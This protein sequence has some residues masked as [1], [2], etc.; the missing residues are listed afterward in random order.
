VFDPF[1]T[2]KQEGQGT[3]LGLAI[4]R[5][6]IEDHHGTIELLSEVGRG[7]LVRLVLP[8]KNGANVNRLREAR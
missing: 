8:I 5:R 4:C 3:G 7:T 6:A 1:F 2:T